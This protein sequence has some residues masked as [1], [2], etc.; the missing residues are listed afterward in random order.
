[1]F[2][3]VQSTKSDVLLINLSEVIYFGKARNN[4]NVVV[5][6]T[7]GSTYTLLTSIEDI[8]SQIRYVHN[9]SVI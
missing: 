8:K 5:V 6:L 4:S 2:I 3:T 9:S 7:D 1:M